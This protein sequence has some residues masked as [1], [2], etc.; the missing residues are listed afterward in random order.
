MPLPSWSQAVL[1]ENW[2]IGGFGLY[3]HWPFCQ[4]KC[5]YCDFNSHLSATIDQDEWA[6]AYVKEIRCAST[7]APGRML[8][9]VYFGGG[10]P[11]LMA[12]KTVETVLNE[13]SGC[14]TLSNNV[15]IT[16]EANP[17]S[18]EIGKFQEFRTAGVNRVSIGVQALNEQDL[19]ALGRLHDVREAETALEIANST[20]SRVNFDLIYARQDQSLKDWEIELNRALTLSDGHL[21]LYQLTIEQGTA[22]GDRFNLGKLRGLPNED[23]SANMYSLTQDLCEAHGLNSY[24][25]SNHAQIG[26]ESVHNLVYWKGGDYAC[27]GPGA[28]GRMTLGGQ[29]IAIECFSNPNKWLSAVNNNGLGEKSRDILSGADRAIEYVMMGLRV[30][31]GIDLD[32]L[33]KMDSTSINL[34]KINELVELNLVKVD[35]NQLI[36]TKTGRPILN[37][38]LREL[39]V[40]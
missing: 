13:I 2:Q 38:I 32:R 20:F 14:F 12:P 22:F 21:S 3:I 40:D 11:S 23:L 36:V 31:S 15:E 7:E 5:P 6:Q 34:C 24:E 1:T 17:T 25:V 33:H 30:Q 19:K 35:E 18:V 16:L 9:S 10:T 26:Q 37:G 29:R 8:S 4:S 28:H 39:L 27:I